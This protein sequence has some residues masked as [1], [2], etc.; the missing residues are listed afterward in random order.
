MCYSRH[1]WRL[2]NH[3]SVRARKLSNLKR[4]C[5]SLPNSLMKSLCAS[6]ELSKISFD[7]YLDFLIEF[8][9][10]WVWNCKNEFINF[11][12][13]LFFFILLMECYDCIF[14]IQEDRCW[15]LT[16]NRNYVYLNLNNWMISLFRLF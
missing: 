4:L 9:S 15:W 13:V 7:F 14:F 6:N 2:D 12:K 5:L 16:S 11:F 8:F 10:G 3:L 1:R